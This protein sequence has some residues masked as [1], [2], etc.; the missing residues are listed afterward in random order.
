M[1]EI[2]FYLDENVDPEVENQLQ[3]H[4]IESV[5]ARSLGLLGEKDTPHLKLATEM[6]FVLC[7]HDTDFL[8]LHTTITDHFGIIFAPHDGATIGG[9]VRVL[10]EI[11]GSETA[12]NFVGQLRFVNV[13]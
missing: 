8:I 5:S 4:G 6:E 7:T 12:E 3:R 2:R 11:H 10:R 1:S 13:R 9:W